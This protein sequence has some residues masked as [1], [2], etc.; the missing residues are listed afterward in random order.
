MFFNS[1]GASWRIWL[2]IG[3]G[4][5]LYGYY[6]WG[7]LRVPSDEELLQAVEMQYQA[8]IARM[9]QHAGDTP[10]TLTREWQ[11]KYR[12]AIYHERMAP[13]EKARKRIQST[14]GIGLMLMVMAGGMFVMNYLAGKPK[15]PG[16]GR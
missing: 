5:C 2:V 9:Q 11:D 8:E 7:N 16:A 13:I 1:R 4:L 10:V 15:D 3:L 14:V 6:E 12:A